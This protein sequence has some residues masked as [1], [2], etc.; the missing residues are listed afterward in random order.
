MDK[1]FAKI[2]SSIDHP[3][4]SEEFKHLLLPV[5]QAIKD[6]H[7]FLYPRK[8]RTTDGSIPPVSFGLIDSTVCI[9]QSSPKYQ[10]LIGKT[11]ISINNQSIDE[12][13]PL[14]ESQIYGTDG[15]IQTQRKRKLLQNFVRLYSR[16]F[17]MNS[18]SHLH[19]EFS[20][21]TSHTF[22]YSKIN[23]DNFL[24]KWKNYAPETK[25]IEIKHINSEIILL[26][27]NTFELLEKDLEDINQL[28]LEAKIKPIKNLIIDLRDNLGGYPKALEHLFSLL[29]NLPFRS[30]ILGKVNK[31]GTYKMFV[32]CYNYTRETKNMYPEYQKIEGKKGFYLPYSHFLEYQPND[33]IHFGGKIKVLIN[34]YSCSASTVFTALMRKHKRGVIIGRETGST[35]YQ[36]NATN[37][38]RVNLNNSGLELR[39]PLVKSIFDEK[40]NSDIPWGRGVIPDYTIDIS[41]AEFLGNEDKILDFTLNLI[42]EENLEEAV[43]INEKKQKQTLLFFGLPLLLLLVAIVIRKKNREKLLK[44]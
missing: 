3:L 13:I 29:T 5:L 40:G 23:R 31:K 18:G 44:W 8:Y 17:S 39:I 12:I 42:E 22:T 28:I 1:L 35:Y 25:R 20:D 11:I 36:L 4:T 7:T 33:S 41:F 9:Y 26:N 10:H 38:A 43:I 24:P 30:Q 32:N 34:E 16:Y 2:S 6:S 37:F 19:L 21:K 27:I 15:Y 14:I